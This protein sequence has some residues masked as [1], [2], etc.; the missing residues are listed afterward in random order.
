MGG[1]ACWVEDDGPG[2]RG[3]GERSGAI[4]LRNTR[5]RL[6]TI[7]GGDATVSFETRPEGGLRVA[8]SLPIQRQ[9]EPRPVEA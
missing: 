1:F 7:Y 4:G 8:F 2:L 6:D 3:N 5:E 9:D